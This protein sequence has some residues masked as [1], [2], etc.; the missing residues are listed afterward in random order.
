M[1]AASLKTKEERVNCWY[2]L[3]C[4]VQDVEKISRRVS[5]LG[6]NVFRPMLIKVSPRTDCNSFR[7]TQKPM[8]PNYLF[9][10]FD[11]HKVHTTTITNIPG[12]IA[13]VRFGGEP[14][15]VPQHIIN[16]LEHSK[17]VLLNL[18]DKSVECLSAAP[19]LLAEIQHIAQITSVHER[20]CAF[21]RFLESC[22]IRYSVS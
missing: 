8:L 19:L 1:G 20:Q 21:L 4:T 15:I 14:C 16:E 6:I 13:F 5:A 18:Q 3:Y 22:E 12:A 9:L 7:Y 17:E 10:Q 2:V 11:I